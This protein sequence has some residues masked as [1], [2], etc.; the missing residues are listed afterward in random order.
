MLNFE[1]IPVQ[2]TL[3][4]HPLSTPFHKV[5]LLLLNVGSMYVVGMLLWNFIDFIIIAP[6]H[7]VNHYYVYS[8]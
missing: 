5:L 1:K 7:Y 8:T 6:V 2:N 3:C 4:W